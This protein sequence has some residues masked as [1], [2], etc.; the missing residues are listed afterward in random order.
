MNLDFGVVRRVLNQYFKSTEPRNSGPSWLTTIGHMKDSLW[1][2]D[3]FRCESINLKSHMVML[4]INQFTRRII[5]FAVRDNSVDGPTTCVMFN[6][7]ISGKSPPKYLSTHLTH[8]PLQSIEN[9]LKF[10]P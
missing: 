1:S 3:L 5:G 9:S 7:I 10:T 8:L 4:V 6:K 2:I